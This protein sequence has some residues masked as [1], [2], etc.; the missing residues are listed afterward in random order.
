MSQKPD[1]PSEAS[2]ALSPEWTE[3][4][5]A[6]AVDVAEFGGPLEA[7]RFLLRRKRIFREAA[8]LGIPKEML[9]PFAPN[10][11]GFEQ[12]VH[13]AFGKLAGVAAE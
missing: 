13:D 12:R 5:S 7:S 3:Y 2:D 4:E 8:A 10:R 9:T 6:W 11:P 1:D